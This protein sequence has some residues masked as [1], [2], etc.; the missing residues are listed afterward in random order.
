[1]SL[2]KKIIK[3]YEDKQFAKYQKEAEERAR[4]EQQ[5]QERIENLLN[6]DIPKEYVLTLINNIEDSTGYIKYHVY[7]YF[8]CNVRP[9][10]MKLL[11]QYTAIKISGDDFGEECK[12]CVEPTNCFQTNGGRIMFDING[13]IWYGDKS[14]PAFIP[15]QCKTI[16]DLNQYASKVNEKIRKEYVTRVLR[17]KD[18]N[19]RFF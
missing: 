5:K 16:D 3:N 19:N 10:D 1:M 15:E 12:F 9:A 17:N 8:L 13:R 18:I 11:G 6:S 14:I 2:L 7:D 4:L